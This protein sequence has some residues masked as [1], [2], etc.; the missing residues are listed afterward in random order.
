MSEGKEAQLYGLDPFFEKIVVGLSST[1]KKFWDQIGYLIDPE[2]LSNETLKLVHRANHQIF[3]QK[4]TAPENIAVVIQRVYTWA[5]TGQI[6]EDEVNEVRHFLQWAKEECPNFGIQTIIDELKPVIVKQVQKEA[7]KQGIKDFKKSGDLSKT[8]AMLGSIKRIG[9]G[10]AKRGSRLG[11]GLFANELK[12]MDFKRCPTGVADL[13]TIMNGGLK[14]G[15]FIVYLGST[16]AGKSMSLETLVAAASTNG[17]T[18]ALASLELPLPYQWARYIGNVTDLPIEDILK[19]QDVNDEAMR[20]LR[21]LEEEGFLSQVSMEYFSPGSTTFAEIMDWVHAEEEDTGKPIQVLAID[22][23]N[24]VDD[25]AKIKHEKQ[26]AVAGKARDEA[27]ESGRIVASAA[28]ADAEGMNTKKTKILQPYHTALSKDIPRAADYV[29]T[30]NPRDDEGVLY[31]VGKDRIGSSGGQ[32]C[33]PL[34]TD[35]VYGRMTYV[36][37]Q[38]WPF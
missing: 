38:N 18:C 7:I 21:I 2:L 17:F 28:Q 12:V 13:D 1:S 3:K 27:H 34:P 32:Q 16:G 14:F 31:A 35:W 8:E 4:K 29:V 9:A 22:T 5:D 6:D 20:R 23:L 15:T 24:L 19:Y 25:P 37:R 11:A 26:G 10:K 33:G 36:D 30:L